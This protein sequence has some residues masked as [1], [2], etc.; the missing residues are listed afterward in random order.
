[1]EPGT[2][3]Q[4]LPALLNPAVIAMNSLGMTV[5]GTIAHQFRNSAKA[6]VEYSKERW[7]C[8][9]PGAKAVLD[10]EKLLKRSAAR[11]NRALASGFDPAHDD[12]PEHP[13]DGP[14]M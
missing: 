6:K 3:A 9:L 13:D 4:L 5:E 1:M 2:R 14:L 12:R 8:K 10:T 11:L 7:L